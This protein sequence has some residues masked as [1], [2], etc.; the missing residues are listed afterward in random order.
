MQ[1]QVVL[2]FRRRC[3][4]Y[5]RSS[6]I[7]DN[8]A[9]CPH[10]PPATAGT[11]S[12]AFGGID[13]SSHEPRHPTTTCFERGGRNTVTSGSSPRVGLQQLVQ[14]ST[15]FTLESLHV[16]QN[17]STL[18]TS[19]LWAHKTHGDP[20]FSPEVLLVSASSKHALGQH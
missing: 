1:Y 2:P 6:R 17:F 14:H 8:R 13:I 10:S 11:M 19:L 15:A 12:Y 16:V 5:S 20:C 18:A 9:P 7:D 4:K 3:R